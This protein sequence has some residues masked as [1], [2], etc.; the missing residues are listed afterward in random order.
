MKVV[1]YSNGCPRC[2]V[3]EAKLNLKNVVFSKTD[4]FSELDSYTTAP[5]LKVNDTVY[6]FGEAV[7]WINEI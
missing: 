5:L 2:N 4:D 7:K 3:L 6:E 1:L